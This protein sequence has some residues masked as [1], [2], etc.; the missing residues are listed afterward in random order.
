M[1]I[2]KFYKSQIHEVDKNDINKKKINVPMEFNSFGPTTVPRCRGRPFQL[3]CARERVKLFF[4]QP[5]ESAGRS[6]YDVISLIH[7]WQSKCS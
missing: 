3:Q 7:L 5:L 6:G 1:Q 4:T 2:K